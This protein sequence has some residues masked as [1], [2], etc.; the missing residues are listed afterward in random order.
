MKQKKNGYSSP[1]QL[2]QDFLSHWSTFLKVFACLS[3][4]KGILCFPLFVSKPRIFLLKS[5]LLFLISLYTGWDIG[6]QLLSLYV[7]AQFSLMV[8]DE[9]LSFMVS[10]G[11]FTVSQVAI[12]VYISEPSFQLVCIFNFW[13]LSCCFVT[14]ALQ[15]NLKSGK[16]L[17]LLCFHANF[18]IEKK[19]SSYSGA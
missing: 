9:A 3:A 2:L 7:N 16:A 19:D 4:F 14:V 10:F 13:Q 5:S 1:F 6:C 17:V 18:R 8:V 11:T 12:P 15:Y